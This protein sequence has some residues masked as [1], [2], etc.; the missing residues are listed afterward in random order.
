MKISFVIPAYNE[1]KYI[2]KCLD[3][4][5]RELKKDGCDAEIIVVN[6]ASTDRT[7]E[8]AKKYSCVKIV[9]EPKKGLPCAR[10]AG[11][12]AATGDIIANVDADTMLTTGWLKMVFSEFSK[13]PKLVALSGPHIH[14]DLPKKMRVLARFFY[15]IGFISYIFNRFVFNV[16]SMLQGGNFIIRR[17]ALQ[18]IGG[19]NTDIDFYGED[20]D[21]ARRLHKVGP[22]KFTFNL[23]IYASGRRLANEG[24]LTMALRYGLNYFWMIFLKRPFNKT[25]AD[26]RPARCGD[27]LK[28]NPVK[29]TREF[30]LAAAVI[31]ALFVFLA[32]IGFVGYYLLKDSVI[33]TITIPE[34]KAE[35]IKAG[36]SL[37]SFSNKIKNALLPPH[38]YNGVVQ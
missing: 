2:G 1:E 23:P 35:T 22:V 18:T 5:L 6:N 11:F 8:V 28:Y 24:A 16:G 36:G 20:S 21:L 31:T 25:S 9:D 33:A 26:I 10:H 27:E 17:A 38:I 14:Y 29:K 13:N 37:R 34:I 15:Y 19:F 4:I 30:L 32:G 12:L 3:S 7:G